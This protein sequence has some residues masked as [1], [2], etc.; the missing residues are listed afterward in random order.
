MAEK[1]TVKKEEVIEAIEK[2][3]PMVKIRLE[4]TRENKLPLFVSINGKNWMIQRGE[5]VTIP[6]CV[7]EQIQHHNKMMAERMEFEEALE[8]SFSKKD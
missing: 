2:K 7:Y 8:A 5:E 6:L 1:K 3:E 4:K